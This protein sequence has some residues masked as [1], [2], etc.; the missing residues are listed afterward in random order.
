M[1]KK[2]IALCI[3][4]I[5]CLSLISCRS[6]DIID[7][8]AN[9]VQAVD[10]NVLSVKNGTCSSYEGIT[11]GEA[12]DS[13]FSL[14]TWKYFK[15]TQEG[16]DEDGDGKPDYTNDNIDVVEF[17]G[18]CMYSDVEVKARIQFTLDKE[19]GTF[20]A[21]YLAFNEVPQN[22]LMLNMLISKAFESGLEAK[23]ITQSAD[24]KQ[25]SLNN[26]E[27]SSISKQDTANYDATFVTGMY[28]AE[29]AMPYTMFGININSNFDY[30]EIGTFQMTIPNSGIVWSGVVE[31]TDDLEFNL[32]SDDGSIIN[33]VL[34]VIDQKKGSII[35]DYQDNINQVHYTFNMISTEYEESYAGYFID[36][37]N[38][39]EDSSYMLYAGEYQTENY[40]GTCII[41]MYSS[42]EG[43]EIGNMSV[44]TDDLELQGVIIDYGLGEGRY[45]FQSDIGQSFDI[46]ITHENDYYKIELYAES[47]HQSFVLE[48]FYMVQQYIS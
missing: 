10:E 17:T 15:G 5:T 41:N 32:N 45:V 18:S 29:N 6:D 14:P 24:N 31:R 7:Q 44:Q 20:D 47:Q 28:E 43:S 42:L 12:F 21:T 35:L 37:N 48:T 34:N 8:T 39:Y 3:L 30:G 9:I 4:T 36:D 23:G 26:N 46:M 25:L 11:Y 19:N 33:A 2:L 27:E 13:F 38:Y 40:S 1:K 16:P 22:M